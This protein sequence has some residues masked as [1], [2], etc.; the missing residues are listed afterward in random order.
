MDVEYHTTEELA[1]KMRVASQTLRS[2]R[3]KGEG[4]PF[5]RFGRRV[6]YPVARFAEWEAKQTQGIA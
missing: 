5:V 4:P 2:W 6:L 3:V 1:A